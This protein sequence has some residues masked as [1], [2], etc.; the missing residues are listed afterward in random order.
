MRLLLLYISTCA[1]L[2]KAAWNSSEKIWSQQHIKR[3]AF[4]GSGRE[5]LPGVGREEVDTG[6]LSVCSI[7]YLVLVLRQHLL[8]FFTVFFWFSI[9]QTMQFFSR[10]YNSDYMRLAHEL[11]IRH[12]IFLR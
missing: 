2:H 1:S 12:N 8:H 5:L 7:F 6:K 4:R 9:R 10:T 3:R 11:Q